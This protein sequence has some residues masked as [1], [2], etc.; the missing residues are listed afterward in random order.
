MIKEITTTTYYSTILG[1]SYST[2][3]EAEYA[4][5]KQIMRISIKAEYIKSLVDRF[6]ILR[7]EY[8]GVTDIENKAKMQ[9]DLDS[10]VSELMYA[11]VG[12]ID[13]GTT[14]KKHI[15]SLKKSKDQKLDS[16]ESL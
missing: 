12:N 2:R 10:I 9:D 3:S 16:Q 5:N 14:Y 11:G 15:R 6:H 1:R 13:V 7:N 8:D 4:E